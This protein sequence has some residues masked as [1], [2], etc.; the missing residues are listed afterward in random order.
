MKC[1]L[2]WYR[3]VLVM[4]WMIRGCRIGDPVVKLVSVVS[5]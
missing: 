5:I 1:F 2:F 4:S 3:D